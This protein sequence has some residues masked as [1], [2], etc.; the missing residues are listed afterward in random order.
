MASS[1]RWSRTIDAVPEAASGRLRD[2]SALRRAVGARIRCRQPKLD[3]EA[4]R[5][6]HLLFSTTPRGVESG[7]ID[8]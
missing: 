3:G 5:G 4:S 7:L 6:R 2:W 8:S 1:Q